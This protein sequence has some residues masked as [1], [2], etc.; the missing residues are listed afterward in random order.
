MLKDFT[1]SSQFLIHH[2]FL[3][4]LKEHIF[5]N[6]LGLALNHSTEYPHQ[7]GGHCKQIGSIKLLSSE[8]TR[9]IIGDIIPK[10]LV[11]NDFSKHESSQV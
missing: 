4:I 7:M 11:T 5:V 1:H 3:L 6:N 8:L 10:S 2:S 9:F